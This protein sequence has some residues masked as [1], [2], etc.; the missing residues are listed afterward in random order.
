MNV[1]R[2][3]WA[4]VV[5]LIGGMTLVSLWPLPMRTDG[6]IMPARGEFSDLAISHWPMQSLWR[7]SVR[8]RGEWPLWMATYF[9]GQPLAGNPLAGFHYPPNW[10]HAA[11]PTETAFA[12]LVLAHMW[13]G[14]LGMYALMRKGA[15]LSQGGALFSAV[16]FMF[17]PRLA[18]H[19]GAGHV[20][21]VY[22]WAWLPWCAWAALAAR[23]WRGGWR[24]GL[25]LAL[26]FLADVRMGYYAAL[27]AAAI[28]AARGVR[29]IRELPLQARHR[30]SRGVGVW[31]AAA[32]AFAG[33]A[34]ALT[35]PLL[36]LLGQATRVGLSP[37][38]AMALSLPPAALLGA[39]LPLEPA[40]HEWSTYLGVPVVAAA[41]V[42]L[43][44]PR[45]KIACAL[46][47]C[48]ALS[49]VLALGAHTPLYGVV[50]RVLPGLSLLRVPAR[51]W[52]VALG[53]VAALAGTGL[54]ALTAIRCDTRAQWSATLALGA[55]V[56]AAG[57]LCGAA[58]AMSLGD[59]GVYL[60]FG[61]AVAVGIGSLVLGM[62]GSAA[63]IAA[64]LILSAVFADVVGAARVW[65]RLAPIGEVVAPG[66][67]V[68]AYLASLPD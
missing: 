60:R 30:I 15:G 1:V 61:I 40:T 38:G 19:L 37:Q 8:E 41:I 42:A 51:F 12:V 9:S 50:L 68:A 2:R 53:C 5:L 67:E 18:A 27:V 64:A 54:D 4:W 62:R 10:L 23:S 21:I 56:V 20:S 25:A 13:F 35:F 36:E 39:V 22:G 57:A 65:W 48:V 16:T 34:A 52:I 3:E 7:E 31:G 45:R 6:L 33:G 44:G 32:L 28:G 14:A 17:G 47:G 63:R 66:R 59:A 49:A 24:L 29:A 58:L 11:L 43:W 46:W 26:A 55:L